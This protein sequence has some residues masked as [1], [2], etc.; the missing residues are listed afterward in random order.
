ML[1]DIFKWIQT[2]VIALIIGIIWFQT[3]FTTSY[4][5]QRGSLVFFAYTYIAGFNPA[6][7]ALFAF[8]MDRA[9]VVRE[10]ASGSYRLLAYY[11][12]KFIM[13][14]PWYFPTSIL[15]YIIFYFMAHL[16]YTP[17]AFFASYFITILCMFVSSSFGLAISAATLPNHRLAMTTL[18]VFVLIFLA[19]GGFFVESYPIWINWMQ[20][21]SY[22]KYSYNALVAVQ[23]DTNFTND[24][25][26][27][28]SAAAYG[29]SPS[30]TQN[31]TIKSQVPGHEL[32][33]YYF[34]RDSF[35]YDPWIDCL[36]LLGFGWFFRIAGYFFLSFSIKRNNNLA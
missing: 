22:I 18:T 19:V 25:N 30:N 5:V 23:S 2:V 16:L 7:E 24:N 36:I 6:F 12:S 3:P 34:I 29:S 9:V 27:T 11:I 17:G 10:R 26:F 28:S 1:F 14:V 15:F 8:P 35:P 21:C 4:Y 33:R 31:V 13:E 20:Y 32:A